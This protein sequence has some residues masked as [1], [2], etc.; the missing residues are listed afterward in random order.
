[1]LLASLAADEIVGW[2]GIGGIALVS[3]GVALFAYG[4]GRR[5]SAA[6]VYAVLAGAFS[7]AYAFCDANGARHS[8]SVLGYGLTASAVN[9]VIFGTFHRVRNKVSIVEALRRHAG[10]ATL[11]SAA[12]MLSYVLILWVWSRAPIALGAALRDTS[13]V[14]AALIATRLGERLTP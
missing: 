6:V 13:V 11:G 7:A 10:M 12:A 8:P 4:A 2:I 9:A 3:G 14:F 5:G 1:L